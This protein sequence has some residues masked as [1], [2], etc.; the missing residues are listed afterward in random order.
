M[1]L[2]QAVAGAIEPVLVIFGEAAAGLGHPAADLHPLGIHQIRHRLR[3]G[4]HQKQQLLG[5]PGA[6]GE[7]PQIVAH[8]RLLHRQP[9]AAAV[10]R[11]KILVRLIAPGSAGEAGGRPDAPPEGR[12]GK[13]AAAQ[14]PDL[15]LL[16]LGQ[17]LRPRRGGLEAQDRGQAQQQRKPGQPRYRQQQDPGDPLAAGNIVHCRCRQQQQIFHSSPKHISAAG[18]RARLPG[19]AAGSAPA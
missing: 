13:G 1:Q 14:Q 5:F 6:E 4:T 16:A 8:P 12:H 19:S 9:V 18:G 7:K 2:V 11:G 17:H 15:R 3:L 10:L